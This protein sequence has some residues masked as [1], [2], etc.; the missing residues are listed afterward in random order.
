[1]WSHSLA[2]VLGGEAQHGILILSPRASAPRFAQS[3]WACAKIS[4]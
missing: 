3:G 2:E 1:M 4:G